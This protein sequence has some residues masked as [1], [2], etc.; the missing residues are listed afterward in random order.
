MQGLSVGVV[1]PIIEPLW[2]AKQVAARLGVSVD[3]VH[4]HVSRKEPRLPVINLGD[5]RGR[6]RGCLRFRPQDIEKFIEEQF[7]RSMPKR[8]M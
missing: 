5:K 7:K 3:W 8:L 4:D 6:G 1:R 2:T